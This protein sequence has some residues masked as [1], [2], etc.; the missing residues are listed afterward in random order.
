MPLSGTI[1][2]LSGPHTYALTQGGFFLCFL[3]F[4]QVNSTTHHKF[5]KSHSTSSM[6]GIAP[7]APNAMLPRRDSTKQRA[8]LT[9]LS[10]D[11]PTNTHARAD[12]LNCS[13]G[14][15][16]LANFFEPTSSHLRN[17]DHEAGSAISSRNFRVNTWQQPMQL[18]SMLSAR[19]RDVPSRLK[20]DNQR[21]CVGDDLQ[22]AVVD[23]V[24]RHKVHLS[25][26]DVRPDSCCLAA[27]SNGNPLFPRI[28]AT[29][30]GGGQGTQ[31]DAHTSN[32]EERVR[33][34]WEPKVNLQVGK[35]RRELKPEARLRSYQNPLC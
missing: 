24:V 21:K 17:E 25:D 7:S 9:N 34:C 2:R 28:P 33:N 32:G 26:N 30:R 27:F 35:Q 15:Q 29:E 4:L 20:A 18:P 13:K 14:T 19:G 1:H 23:K 6:D 11:E 3:F 8:A 22:P 10:N 12:F 16:K 5:P 31:K